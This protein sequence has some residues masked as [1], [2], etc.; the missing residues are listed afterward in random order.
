V[1]RRPGFI[2]L[3]AG[4]APGPNCIWIPA[5]NESGKHLDEILDRAF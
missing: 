4:L 5:M 2:K 3:A 1:P